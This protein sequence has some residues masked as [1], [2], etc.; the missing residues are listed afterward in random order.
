V[1]R[2]A[3]ERARRAALRTL[4]VPLILGLLG[5]GAFWLVFVGSGTAGG[6]RSPTAAVT[7][8]TFFHSHALDS[9]IHFI[10]RLPVGYATGG[11][12]YPVIYFLHGLPA[13][14]SSYQRMAW[15][16]DA[17]ERTGRPAILVVPQGASD[18]HTDP[19]YHDWGPGRNWETALAA[20]LPTYVDRHYRTIRH[21]TARALIGLSAG[22]YGATILALHHPAVYSVIESWSGYFRPTDPT[23]AKTLELGSQAADAEANVHLLVPELRSQ[24]RRHPTF[25]AFYVGR[26]DPTFVP[27]NIALDA[28]LKRAG[29]AHAFAIYPGG[30][31]LALWKA[32]A[33]GWLS[34]ALRHLDAPTRA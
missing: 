28:E 32:H 8:D 17:L 1:A 25:F 21:R 11:R 4:A 2:I 20:E 34:M 27:A 26:S 31:S 19:E 29:V 3:P 33:T 14:P 23:G 24:F 9:R 30:H 18:G 15:V 22:G 13:G 7:L 5:F 16:G 12:H 6:R 10:I